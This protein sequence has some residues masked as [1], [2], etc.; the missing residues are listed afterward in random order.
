MEGIAAA[1]AEVPN[2]GLVVTGHSLGGAAAV[3]GAAEMRKAGKRL[4]L[5]TYGQPRAGNEAFS[6]IVTEQAGGNFRVTHTSDA[7]PKLPPMKGPANSLYGAYSHI[8]PEYWIRK[9]FGN[10]G[11]I[12]V[13][14]GFNNNKGNAGT[15]QLKFN[16]LAHIGYFQRN[17]YMCVLPIP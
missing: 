1:E 14:Q 2:Y 16:I 13:L 15:G 6:K 4:A 11:N 7:V 10:D 9:G 12:A 8:S 17:M 5:F 3:F